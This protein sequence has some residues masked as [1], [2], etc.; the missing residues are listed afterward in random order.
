MIPLM[1][2]V[3][4]ELQNMEKLGVISCINEPTEWCAPMVVV[5]KLDHR[6]RICINLTKLNENVCREHHQMHVVE[7]ALAQ[8]SGACLFSKLDARSG[9]WQTPLSADSR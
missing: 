8:V 3:E 9:F 1:E 7:Q 6:V 5:P 2:Q 4:E